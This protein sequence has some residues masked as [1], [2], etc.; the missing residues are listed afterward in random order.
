MFPLLQVHVDRGMNDGQKVTFRGE[1]DQEVRETTLTLKIA[2]ICNP[3]TPK[4][5]KDQLWKSKRYYMKVL[6]T[7]F[8]LNGHTLHVDTKIHRTKTQGRY[9]VNVTTYVKVR[10]TIILT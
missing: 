10:N 5:V 6:L 7:I 8:H 1:G 9:K 2:L 4:S 3:F